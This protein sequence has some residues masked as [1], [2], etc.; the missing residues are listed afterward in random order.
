[1][2]NSHKIFLVSGWVTGMDLMQMYVEVIIKPLEKN[3]E[4]LRQRVYHKKISLTR[5]KDRMRLTEMENLLFAC[6]RRFGQF[7]DQEMSFYHEMD[8]KED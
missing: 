7:M 1:M 8:Q 3:V 4:E 5:R 6:Y 2:Q